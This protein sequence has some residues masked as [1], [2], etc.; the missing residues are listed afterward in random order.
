MRIGIIRIDRMGDMILT[1]PILK[2][3]KVANPSAKIEVIA[4]DKSI[5]VIKNF[6]YISKI[7]NSKKNIFNHQ[8]YDFVLNLSPGW[9]SFFICLFLKSHKKSTLILKSR[10]KKKVFSKL[11]IL[12]LSKIFFQKTLIID[13]LDRFQKLKSIHQT[14][15]MF[16]L[17]K[18][19]SIDY[20]DTIFIEKFL[21]K[22]SI[23]ISKKNI[24]LIHLSSKWINKSYNEI[25]FLELVDRLKSKYDL[26]LTSDETTRKKFKLI[27]EKF[28]IINNNN[29]LNFDSN[30]QV[31]ILDNLNF[32][33]WVQSIYLS[34]LVITPECGC[35]HIAA[36]CQIPL[37]IIYELENKP[38]MIHAEYS[39][40]RSN[41]EKFF[42][43]NRK[44][45]NLLM[46]NL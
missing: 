2:S 45:N 39:P 25:D 22:K 37:K 6:K 33:N 12:F 40:W 4:S 11:F 9:K 3:I 19:S 44:L 18:K 10:Y 41:Y 15:M 1:L 43:G 29:F 5:K 7:I 20:N 31:N 27:Y 38:E 23:F 24:C 21:E 16:R 28:P 46:K 34:S 8:K 32:D 35:S 42:F 26:L 13:R 14:E 36:L 17:L 30:T